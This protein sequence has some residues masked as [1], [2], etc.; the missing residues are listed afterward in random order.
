MNERNPFIVKRGFRNFFSA[1]I[2]LALVEQVCQILDMILAGHFVSADAFSALELVIP[3]ESLITAGLMLLI[4]GA[5][6]I[7]SQFIGEQEF[8]R[9][10]KALSNTLILSLVATSTVALISLIFLNPLIRFLCADPELAGYIKEYMIIYIP[11]LPLIAAYTALS[12]IINVDG[13]P[14]VATFAV[15]LSCVADILLDIILMGMYDLGVTGIAIATLFSYVISVLVF[16]IY[17]LSKRC[18][19]KFIFRI[20]EIFAD[21]KYILKSGVPY[22]MPFLLTSVFCL[23]FNWAALHALGQE[24]VYAW[25]VGYQIMSIGIMLIDSICGT[26]LVTM[27]SML[28]G[29]GDNDGLGILAER[30]LIFCAISVA[31][32]IIPVLLFPGAIAS[33]FGEDSSDILHASRCPIML[34]VTF[35]IPYTLCCLKVYLAQALSRSRLSSIPMLILF[36]LTYFF[37]LIFAFFIPEHLFLSLPAA[38]IVYLSLDYINSSLVRKKHPDWVRFF[39]IP[40]SENIRSM[41]ISIP[42]TK[43]GLNNSLR[44]LEAFLDEI[45]LPPSLSYGINI[46]SEELLMN[47]VEH[48]GHGREDYFFDFSVMEDKDCVKVVVKDAGRPFNPVRNF[49]KTA[50]EAYLDGENMHLSLQILNSMC[51]ELSYNYMYGQNTIYMSFPK[52]HSG[53][54]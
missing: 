33:L 20:R 21:L 13:K 45:S 19:F 35:L 1:T 2:I 16:A 3:Y 31:A 42:Y 9:S 8:D 38:G 40:P 22:S 36:P 10:N 49:K 11:T 43:D 7:A 44:Q 24:G 37:I 41:Y 53:Q 17:L 14:E 23:I 25:G 48:N 52:E 28:H 6:V 27:G 47:I 4:G 39:L 50:A 54:S 32:V 15:I 26:I 29:C 30:C 46:C 18:S 12:E 51:K 34:S 5:G